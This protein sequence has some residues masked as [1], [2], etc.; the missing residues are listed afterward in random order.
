MSIIDYN[1]EV[2]TPYSLSQESP[3]VLVFEQI[4]PATETYYAKKRE[5]LWA[6]FHDTG[7][8]NPDVTYWVRCMSQRYTELKAEWDVRF[9]AWEEYMTRL[10]GYSAIDLAD[11]EIDSTSTVTGKHY[12]PPVTT[13]SG[14]NA[15]AY[16]DTQ[17]VTVNSFHQDTHGGLEPA[18]VGEYMD[19]VENPY[20]RWASEF[21]RLFYWGL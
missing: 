9:R 13:Q 8:G 7:I 3:A 12:D 20:N 11:S 1:F 2:P 21:D 16:L 6:R 14:S 10:S 4:I 17:D 15:T 19:A 18:T 5:A